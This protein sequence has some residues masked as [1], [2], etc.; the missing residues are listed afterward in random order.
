ME[1]LCRNY[2]AT[3]DGERVPP[4]LIVATF[5]FD[6]LCIHSFRDG[7]GAWRGLAKTLLPQVHGF[8]VAPY[9]SLERLVGES[10]EDYYCNPGGLLAGM[11][12]R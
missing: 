6:F 5:V 4:L 7:K 11:A 12:R 10:K 8:Y 9:I 3:C 1:A 2:R